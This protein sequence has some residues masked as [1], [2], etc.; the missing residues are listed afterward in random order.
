MGVERRSDTNRMPFLSTTLVASKL[1]FVVG[2]RSSKSLKR[3]PRKIQKNTTKVRFPFPFPCFKNPKEKGRADENT[4][5]ID[6]MRRVV[7][8]CKRHL[9]QEE[10]AKKDT[11]SKSY[12]SLKNWGHDALKK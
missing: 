4:E 12:K 10:K 1:N 6:H 7:A 3:T 5:D 11:N 8:Y 9:A 2:G